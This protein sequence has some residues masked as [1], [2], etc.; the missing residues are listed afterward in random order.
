[1]F[2]KNTVISFA[3]MQSLELFDLLRWSWENS[4]HIVHIAGYWK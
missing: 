2:E 1:L 4:W 3:K